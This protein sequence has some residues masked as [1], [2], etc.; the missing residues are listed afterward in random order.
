MN[1]IKF[2][3][4][5]LAA[6]ISASALADWS[7]NVGYAWRSQADTSF[8][9]A[10]AQGRS[11]GNYAD[12]HVNDGVTA[13]GY[14]DWEGDNFSQLPSRTVAGKYDYALLL[15][16]SEANGSGGS[17]DSA[18]G[19][20]ASIGC[21]LY[22]QDAFDI[23]AVL[24]FAGYWGFENSSA[25]GASTYLDTYRFTGLLAGIDPEPSPANY[26][27]PE[28][29][30]REYLSGGPG[31]RVTLKSD[32]YQLALG[33]KVTWHAASWLDIYGGAEVLCCFAN[34]RLDAG[35]ASTDEVNNLWGLGLSAG[36]TGWLDESVGIFGQIGYEWIEDDEISVQGVR[37]ETDYSS[38]ILSV[39]LR[40]RF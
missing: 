7:F 13:E 10:S 26:D 32:L 9:G 39:G 11:G 40:F 3:V 27:I 21:D 23:S 38:L 20:T 6:A 29:E 22:R 2:A 14:P 12:G 4:C 5:T 25:G 19:L 15:N 24:R 28:F 1:T 30:G 31:G 33:P 36:F 17:D 35:G 34:D 8:K 18:S 37:A 16:G